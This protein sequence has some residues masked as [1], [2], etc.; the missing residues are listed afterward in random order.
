MRS[1]PAGREAGCTRILI[2]A[3]I[4]V[5]IGGLMI[6]RTPEYLGKKIQAREVKL[7]GLGALVMPIIVLVVTA[8]AVSLHAGRAGP[9]NAGPHGFTEILYALTSQGNNNGSAMAGLTGNTAFYN[10]IGAVDMLI[11]RFGIIIP[12]LALAG[13]LAAKNVVPASLGTFRTDN[14]MFVGPDHRRDRDHRW[15]DLLPGRFARADRR[16]AQPRKVLLMTNQCDHTRPQPP[17]EQP[18]RGPRRG[19][20]S[21]PLRPRRSWAGP[22][23][24]AF[25]KLDPRVQIKNPVMFV[26]LVGTVVTFIEAIAHPGIFDWS[27]T[28]WLFLTVIFANFAEAMAEGRGKAQADTLRRMRSETEARRLRPDGTEERVRGGGAGEGRP[29]GVRGRRPD[30]L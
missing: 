26:V 18:D 8:I 29:R 14:G 24:T 9:L 27:I 16:A 23:S 15:P 30:P 2:Y 12:A 1:P 21:E 19:R 5:F 17:A 10:I 28:I 4:A 20:G 25:K 7:A 3:V 6:G 13:T 11:G 22:S